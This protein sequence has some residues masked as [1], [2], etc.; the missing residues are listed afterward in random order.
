MCASAKPWAVR[1]EQDADASAIDSLLA[2]AFGPGRRAKTSERVRELAGAVP[3]A[4]SRV[5]V[6]EGVVG[7]C[8]RIWGLRAGAEPIWF[9]GPLAVDPL[10]QR[11]G[12]GARLTGEAVTAAC[13]AEARSIVLMGPA[14]FFA[15]FGFRPLEGAGLGWPG[16]VAAERVLWRPVGP[17]AAPPSG[18]LAAP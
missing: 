17:E 3:H 11:D 5:A 18:R 8:C 15:P 4:A 16:P 9:L 13:N 14:A 6:R 1:A 2:R 12:L 10:F 7:G